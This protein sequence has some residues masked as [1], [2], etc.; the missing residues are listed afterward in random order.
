MR[1]A[2]PYQLDG[3]FALPSGRPRNARVA[4]KVG[5]LARSLDGVESD[6]E[7]RGHRDTRQSGLWSSF[8]G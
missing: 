6:F 4:H 2:L 5:K 8:N 7:L 1:R 3:N